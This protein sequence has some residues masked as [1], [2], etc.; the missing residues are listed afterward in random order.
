[1]PNQMLTQT[2]TDGEGF[3]R[4]TRLLRREPLAVHASAMGFSTTVA[5]GYEGAPVL[6]RLQHSARVTGVLRNSEG[7]PVANAKILADLSVYTGPRAQTESLTDADGRFTLADVA[8]GPNLIRA[9]VDGEGL[10]E[11]RV[12]VAADTEIDLQCKAGEK[13]SLKVVFEGVPA[14]TLPLVTM[15]LTRQHLG[16]VAYQPPLF[17]HVHPNGNEWIVEQLPVSDYSLVPSA[18]GLVF[19]PRARQLVKR[20]WLPVVTFKAAPLAQAS[21]TCSLIARDLDGNPIAG[22]DLSLRDDDYR[23]EVHGRTD[24]D[25]RLALTSTY[26]TAH[27]A[28]VRA[29][30]DRWVVRQPDVGPKDGLTHEHPYSIDH[31]CLIDPTHPVEV[32]LVQASTIQGRLLRSDGRPAAFVPVALGELWGQTSRRMG[33]E[34]TDQDGRYRFAGKHHVRGLVRVTSTSEHGEWTSEPLVFD[35]PGSECTVP[36]G[37]LSAPASIQGVVLDGDQKP[38]AGQEVWLR[39][40]SLANGT[41][42]NGCVAVISDRDGRYRFAAAKPGGGYFE[43]PTVDGIP[44]RLHDRFEIEAGKTYTFDLQLPAK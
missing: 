31:A 38:V 21:V 33:D 8:L 32:R 27:R 30:D 5:D 18:P 43:L 42:Q 29:V 35:K 34:L 36:D 26:R 16:G 11:R 20:K 9:W 25:G 4:V 7:K 39:D 10:A 28:T 44:R 37:K 2:T 41:D 14:E 13:Q 40:W 23:T 12:A 17:D 22:V 3:F 6:L 24:A 19:T 1:M 15:T